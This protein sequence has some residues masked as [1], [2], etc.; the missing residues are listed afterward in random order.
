MSKMRRN[1]IKIRSCAIFTWLRVSSYF[2]VDKRPRFRLV[3]KEIRN[4]FIGSFIV[5]EVAEQ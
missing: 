2:R 3:S 4:V 1:L 5:E